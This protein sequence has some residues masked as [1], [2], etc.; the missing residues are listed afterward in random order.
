MAKQLRAVSIDSPRIRQLVH[1]NITT[2]SAAMNGLANAC[3]VP[4]ATDDEQAGLI[5]RSAV[6]YAAGIC[7]SYNISPDQ[8]KELLV[9]FCD[10]K[11]DHPIAPR[12]RN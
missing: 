2:F 12:L 8:F 10:I 6:A 4:G 5:I 1:E 9:L 3:S 7:D 11:I